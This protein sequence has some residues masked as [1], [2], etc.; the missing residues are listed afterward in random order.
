MFSN[1]TEG[2]MF[3]RAWCAR[4]VHAYEGYDLCDEAAGMYAGEDPPAF[5][6]YTAATRENPLGVD[7]GRFEGRVQ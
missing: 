4:C 7:C 3:T 1:S 5:L 6:T 2:D